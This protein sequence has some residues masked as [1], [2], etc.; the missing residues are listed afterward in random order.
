M[1]KLGGLEKFLRRTF[2]LDEKLG[3]LENCCAKPLRL[4][5]N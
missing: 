3:G 5:K 1:K 4:M 2:V